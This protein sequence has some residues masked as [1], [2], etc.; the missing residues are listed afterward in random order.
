MCQCADVDDKAFKRLNSATGQFLQVVFE[1]AQKYEGGNHLL[2]SA[3]FELGSIAMKL[4][5]ND[6]D[7]S[8]PDSEIRR[9]LVKLAATI[10]LLAATGTPEYAFPSD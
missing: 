10:S 6:R 7:R 8:V 3:L 2:E 1:E 5:Q 4:V 9:E